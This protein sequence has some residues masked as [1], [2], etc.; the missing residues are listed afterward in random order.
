MFITM[1]IPQTLRFGPTEIQV[2]V[3]LM[4]KKVSCKLA[5]QEQLTNLLSPSS[6]QN[7]A[8]TVGKGRSGKYPMTLGKFR[9]I[10]C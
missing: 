8:A 2:M 1:N 5:E 4:E 7:Y 3:A 10:T 6:H 9:L